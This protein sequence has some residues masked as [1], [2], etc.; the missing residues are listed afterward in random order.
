MRAFPIFAAQ[1]R[2]EGALP[3]Q[4]RMVEAEERMKGSVV[5]YDTD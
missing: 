2:V 4:V 1:Y 3:A 5:E